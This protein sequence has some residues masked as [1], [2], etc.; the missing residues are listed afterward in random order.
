MPPLTAA[1]DYKIRFNFIDIHQ[2]FLIVNPS[3]LLSKKKS[4]H[5]SFLEI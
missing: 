4:I 2:Y 3:F 1:G 5:Y